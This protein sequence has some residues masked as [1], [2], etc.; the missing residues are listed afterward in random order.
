LEH[1]IS[2]NFEERIAAALGHPSHDP[3]GDPI[4][5]R[6]LTMPESSAISLFDLQQPGQRAVISRV[7]DSDPNLLRYLSKHGLNPQARLRVLEYNPFD[8]NLH[9][10]VEGQADSITLGTQITRQIFV[11]VLEKVNGL[12][13]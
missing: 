7:R 2:E 4:P 6:E 8:G 12:P 13:A 3:H 10:A 5:T 1:V 11:E 9:L